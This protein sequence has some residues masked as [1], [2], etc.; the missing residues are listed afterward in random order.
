MGFEDRIIYSQE[1]MAIA[2]DN[3][4]DQLKTLR[5]DSRYRAMLGDLFVEKLSRWE[6]DI[7][8]QKDAPFTLVVVGDFKRGKSTLINAL[9]GEEV[10]TTDVTTETVTLNRISYGPHSSEAVL[11]DGRSVRL[12]DEELHREALEKVLAQAGEGVKWLELKRPIDLLKQVTIIDTPGTG[13]SMRDFSGVVK[14]SLLQADAVIYIYNVKYPL[15]Q[16]E[17]L[18]LK[19]AVLPQR[20]TTLFL[21]GNY[22]DTMENEENYARIRDLLQ[23]RTAVLLPD[24]ELLTISALDELCR[25]L[26]EERPCEA[27]SAVLENQFGRLR[28]LL[29][30]LVEDKKD[31]VALDRMQR[32][33]SAMTADL[34]T[35]LD[36]MESGLKM[37]R[38]MVAAALERL[39]AEK[40][41]SA[42]NQAAMLDQLDQLLTS[43]QYEASR[44]MNEFL[45]RIEEETRHLENQPTETLLKYYEFYCV[46]LLQEAVS[47]CVEHHQ[48]Q[49]YDWLDH[50]SADISS[51]LVDSIGRRQGVSFR[52]NLDN[53]IWT[54][55]DT[56]GLAVSLVSGTGLLAG[57]ASLVADG[58]SGLMREKEVKQQTPVILSQ[59]AG[60]MTG[61]QLSVAETVQSIYSELSQSARRL[62]EEYFGEQ[63]A[64]AERLI[65]QSAKAAMKEE[66]E[67]EKLQDAVDCARSLLRDVD[68]ALKGQ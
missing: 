23:E 35:E 22:A 1:Q 11:A 55:G 2:L 34:E 15:S 64:E 9:L 29:Y 16:T 26:G 57:M 18:F 42:E 3:A 56:V 49:L 52:M 13:D 14:E 7:R 5:Y 54:K 47:T 41:R 66:A 59:I 58:I 61:L 63:L 38:S 44:W 37:D 62:V 46:D 45:A 8:R 27:L 28:D 51:G 24:A 32:L 39:K 43:M 65:H 48:E 40:E 36:A 33:A 68:A 6:G 19:S 4:L 67:K 31:T 10:V 12:S 60:K 53:R 20:Y 30:A 25:Q 17:Q 21:V 50:I